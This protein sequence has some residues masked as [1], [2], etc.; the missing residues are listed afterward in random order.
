MKKTK[1][2]PKKKPVKTKKS[3]KAAASK[4][5]VSFSELYALKK[6]K[7]KEKAEA[8]EAWKSKKNVPPQDQGPKENSE[9]RPTADMRKTGFGGTRHH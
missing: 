3:P 8:A 7:E 9:L 4:N 6:A 1:S 5:V 2:T